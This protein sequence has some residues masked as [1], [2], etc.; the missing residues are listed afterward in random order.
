[1]SVNTHDDPAWLQCY[2]SA[3]LSSFQRAELNR[4]VW[5][6]VANQ[7]WHLQMAVCLEEIVTEG[8]TSTH[9]HRGPWGRHGA[10]W[11]RAKVTGCLNATSFNKLPIRSVWA[12]ELDGD[13]SILALPHNEKSYVSNKASGALRNLNLDRPHLPHPLCKTT[14]DKKTK[15][16]KKT[17]LSLVQIKKNFFGRLS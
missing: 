9:Y 13:V 3:I 10:K 4:T 17:S 12:P 7:L 5:E 8:L 15:L 2:S 14:Q 1:M 6:C 11:S 16:N